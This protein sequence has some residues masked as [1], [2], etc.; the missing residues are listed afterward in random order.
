[1]QGS[2]NAIVGGH[3]RRG[4]S[5]LNLDPVLSLCLILVPGWSHISFSHNSLCVLF[6]FIAVDFPFPVHIHLLVP[7]EQLLRIFCWSNLLNQRKFL[8]CLGLNHYY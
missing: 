6:L 2:G 8:T 1:M 4:R 3:R 5:Y 7:A